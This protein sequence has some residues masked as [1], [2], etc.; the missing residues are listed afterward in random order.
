MILLL[1]PLA[2]LLWK[3]SRNLSWWNP[4]SWWNDASN[5]AGSIVTQ[6]K[7]WVLGI[8][9]DAVNLVSNDITDVFSWAYDAISAVGNAINY[10]RAILTAAINAVQGFAQT[11]L[12]FA[13]GTA[14]SLFNQA[15]GFARALVNGAIDA[16]KQWLSDLEGWAAAAI[17]FVEV[18][19]STAINDVRSW[20]GSAINFVA[21]LAS[22]ALAAAVKFLEKSIGDAV[23]YVYAIIKNDLIAPIEVVVNVL[24][25]AWDWV[26]WFAE[27][28]FAV[29][30]DVE[31]D[32]I[33]WTDHLAD[34]L[35]EVVEGQHFLDGMNAAAK[36]FGG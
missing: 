32:V 13:I 26:S 19:L 34:D 22:A 28:P 14:Q 30:H 4:V 20:A 11:V 12:A 1:I 10:V 24:K 9:R 18:A 7:N 35:Q 6:I 36:F 8:V 2:F 25:K 23:S 15:V 17:R 16:V 21:Q 31:T 33:S 5:A 27:H 3:R 29:V